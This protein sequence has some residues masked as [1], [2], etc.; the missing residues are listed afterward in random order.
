MTTCWGIYKR[1]SDDPNDLRRGVIRQD[2]DTRAAVDR[3]GGE[4][5]KDYPENDT[6]AYKKKR[7]KLRDADGN[8]Y[9]AYRVIRPVWQQALSDLR[10]GVIDALMV[11]DIDR[12]A[13]DPRDLEDAIE[14]VQYY[15]KRI[16]GASGSIDLMTDSGQAMARVMIA[17]AAK[18]SADTGRRVARNHLDLAKNGR[19]VGGRRAFGWMPDRIEL[20]LREAT[21]IQMGV[22]DLLNA[23]TT[24]YG[25][26]Q[27]WNKAKLK[28]VMGNQWTASKVRQ[29]LTNPRLVGKRVHKNVTYVGEWRPV[30]DQAT[31][32]RLEAVLSENKSR[33]PGRPSRRRYILTGIARCATCGGGMFANAYGSEGKFNYVCRGDRTGNDHSM[34]VQG[35][36]L[37][38][39]VQEA[40]LRI[41]AGSVVATPDASFAGEGRLV[42]I[43]AERADALARMRTKKLKAASAMAMIEL[44]DAE[45]DALLDE[46]ADFFRATS[47]PS[48]RRVT[49]E[50][51]N[52]MDF[53]AQRALLEAWVKYV[54]IHPPAT[55]RTNRF[56]PSR[57]EIVWHSPE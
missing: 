54:M 19:S 21:A 4:V 57:L 50:S 15:G 13:R 1:I 34:Y 51:F 20:D 9:F 29:L 52:A 39:L 36:R 44:L 2:D 23:D 40:V 10:N 26:A 48:A 43:A 47:G 31:W 25:L 55:R 37:D 24:L 6:S 12:L 46:R 35:R 45:E 41:M 14:V 11:W 42:E 17:M 7:I 38:A 32:D 56:D 33:R 28:T 18:S 16:E 8:E 5:T 22:A 30:L 27:R 49:P 53:D 3:R